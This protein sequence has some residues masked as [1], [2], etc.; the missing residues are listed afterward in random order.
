METFREQSKRAAERVEA[1]QQRLE[2]R[3]HTVAQIEAQIEAVRR[4]ISEKQGAERS[5]ELQREED[6]LG[7]LLIRRRLGED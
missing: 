7:E 5:L 1:A 3:Q 6:E 4:R 2:E